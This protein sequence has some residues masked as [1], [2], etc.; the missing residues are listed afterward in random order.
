MSLCRYLPTPSDRMAVLWSLLAINGAVVLEYGPAGTTHYSMILYGKLGVSQDGKLFTTH[1][2][3]DDVVMGDTSR[4]EKAILEVDRC[5]N[6]K[7]IFVVASSI[8][9][10]IGTDIKGVCNEMQE[11]VNAKLVCFEQGGLK[12]D[13]SVGLAESYKLI[14]KELAKKNVEKKEKTYNVF[15]LSLGQYR[16]QSDLWEITQLMSEAFGYTLF[17]TL[18]ESVSADALENLGSATI[19]LCIRDEAV[20]AAKIMQK[21]CGTPYLLACPYGYQ[22]TLDWLEAISKVID[23]PINPI[24]YKR[25]KEKTDEL[26]ARGMRMR[27]FREETPLA[28]VVGDYNRVTGIAQVLKEFHFDINALI[29]DHTLMLIPDK[30][31]DVK[32][33]ENEREKIDILEQCKSQIIFG[34]NVTL[35]ITD[36]SNTKML[37]S[38]PFFK[39]A[40]AKHM[41]I[42]GEKGMDFISEHISGYL[43]SLMKLR[44]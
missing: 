8:S 34:D 25:L 27:M 39:G 26:K 20:P 30:N 40:V 24:L 41:P 11:Q 44:R 12:G 3:E 32:Y 18:C 21:K 16:A 22:G 35:E 14:C 31:P 13:H 33:I 42:I 10:I 36:D 29:C 9:A 38:A 4:L 43:E 17:A 37:V 28:T 15:G 5:S 19:N 7:V 6:A 23:E 2:S 1:M